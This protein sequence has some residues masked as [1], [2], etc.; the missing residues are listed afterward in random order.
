MFYFFPTVVIAGGLAFLYL[1]ANARMRERE[2]V[3]RERLAMIER[4]L[5]PPPEA[6]PGRFQRAAMAGAGKAP[7]RQLKYRSA[8]I[9][10][11]GCGLA[12]IML[13]SFTAG[14]PEVGLGVGGAFVVLGVT[15]VVNSMFG[16]AA[17][18]DSAQQATHAQHTPS[19][20]GAPPPDRHA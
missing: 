7:A 18:G 20:P 5:A 17:W 10:T 2:M 12:L 13:L 1:A 3:H 15:F 4:G 11:I 14:I 8:G 9:I 19:E 6:D 16:H